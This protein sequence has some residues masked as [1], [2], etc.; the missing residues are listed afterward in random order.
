ML[1][2]VLWQCGFNGCRVGEAAVPGPVA[3]SGNWRAVTANI[4]AWSTQADAVMA[5]E[6]D[7]VGLQETRLS[8]LA[9]F[10]AHEEVK[11]QNWQV[12]WGK[13]QPPQQRENQDFV[14]SAWNAKHGG[15]GILIRKGLHVQSVALDSPLRRKL[16]DTGRW[17]HAM[18]AYGDGSDVLH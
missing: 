18:V 2:L 7:I 16:W 9:Q 1:T 12:V 8:E 11:Q 17:V 10:E 15:V 5:L 3:N 14:P 4:T 6:A 13:P